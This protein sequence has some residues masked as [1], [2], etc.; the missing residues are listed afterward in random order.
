M[1]IPR[2]TITDKVLEK[3]E[4]KH[5]VELE[6]AFQGILNAAEWRKER[7]CFTAESLTDSGRKI[8]V[9]VK[10]CVGEWQIVTAWWR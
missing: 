7:S 4:R 5:K 1:R 8:F 2:I 6:D 9:V 3:L 10:R